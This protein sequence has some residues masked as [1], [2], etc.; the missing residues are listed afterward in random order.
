MTSG[1]APPMPYL[2]PGRGAPI[3]GTLAT[4]SQPADQASALTAALRRCFC[5]SDA[6]WTDTTTRDGE[7]IKTIARHFEFRSFDLG[8][9]LLDPSEAGHLPMAGVYAYPDAGRARACLAV[10]R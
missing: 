3:L 8:S 2:W 10:G 6:V 7:M 4:G 1:W 5:D 9:I